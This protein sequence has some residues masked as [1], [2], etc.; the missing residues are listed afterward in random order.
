MNIKEKEIKFK[1]WK[2]EVWDNWWEGEGQCSGCPIRCE[3]RGS[4]PNYGAFN[5]DAELM[6]V[7]R[8]PGSD[9]RYIVEDAKGKPRKHQT[10]PKKLADEVDIPRDYSQYPYDEKILADWNFFWEGPANLFGI[11]NGDDEP[12]DRETVDQHPRQTYFT[13][14]LKC[15]RLPSSEEHMEGDISEPSKLNRQ[16]RNSCRDYLADEIDLVSPDVVLTFGREAFTNTMLALDRDDELSSDRNLKE[17]I[18]KTDQEDLFARY[19][20]APTVIPSYHWSGQFF[21][22]NMSNATAI[23]NNGDDGPTQNDCWE[24]LARSVNSVLER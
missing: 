7:G 22:T 20:T 2:Q 9:P 5:P 17:I 19:G 16:A 23:P 15:S 10:I 8:E 1:Q 3:N 21:T 11:G 12:V 14:S 18:N 4:F 13:N 24:V 6:L